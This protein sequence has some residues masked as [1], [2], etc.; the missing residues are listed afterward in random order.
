MFH[1]AI[2][3]ASPRTRSRKSFNNTFTP[4]W[5]ASIP[6]ICWK[7]ST[8][9][10]IRCG[11]LFADCWKAPAP[12]AGPARLSAPPGPPK[13]SR[14]KTLIARSKSAAKNALPPCI[15]PN[16]A[17]TPPCKPCSLPVQSGPPGKPPVS[18]HHHQP[19]PVTA[20]FPAPPAENSRIP[21]QRPVKHADPL[22]GM[23]DANN[24]IRMKPVANE[25]QSSGENAQKAPSGP[26]AQPAAQ[27]GPG[28]MPLPFS[29]NVSPSQQVAIL[30]LSGQEAG[31]RLSS[32]AS[33][34]PVATAGLHQAC[35][36]RRP[37]PSA[38]I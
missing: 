3:L 21:I 25:N 19:S 18:V 9:K 2:P 20:F 10:S 30:D 34:G 5:P 27:A 6:S 33:G 16:A 35:L 17:P 7:Q 1:S 22:T 8:S 11:R 15:K 31:P 28:P 4:C 23:A 12:L 37:P 36:N 13:L 32:L 14:P 26:V 24:S 38:K 29:W